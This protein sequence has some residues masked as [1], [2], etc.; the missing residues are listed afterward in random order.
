[1]KLEI[2]APRSEEWKLCR[3]LLPETFAEAAQR[4][5]LL[6]LAEGS[7]HVAGAASFCPRA[8]T[9]VGVRVHVVPAFRRHGVGSAMLAAIAARGFPILQGT[10]EITRERGAAQFADRNHFLCTNSLTT[11]EG[12]IAAFRESIRN[13]RARIGQDP[14]LN[15]A[16]LHETSADEVARLHAQYV[17]RQS[18][19]DTWRGL[20]TRTPGMNHSPVV[21]VE[22]RVAGV[23]L[24]EK[25]GSTAVVRSRVAAPGPHTRRINL[26]LLAEALDIGWA[27]GCRKVRFF[28][29]NAHSDTRKLASRLKAEV[30]SIVAEYRRELSR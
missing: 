6:C 13:L 4:D 5:Y 12:G 14:R 26:L 2:R 24:W 28:Y 30:T 29:T 7:A 15:V 16:M 17:A 11:V 18:D 22:G 8:N 23:L 9:A 19:V 27:Q 20:L 10:A 1:M 21:L 3:M 25:D